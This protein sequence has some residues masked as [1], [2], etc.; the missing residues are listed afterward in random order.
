LPKLPPWFAC[1]DGI[2][3]DGSVVIKVTDTCP[4]NYPNNWYS[5]KRWC[6]GDMPHFD[7][8]VWAFERVSAGRDM[9]SQ[10]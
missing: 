9:A 1:R 3:K 8:S 7:L 2:C 6:C 10:G 4:C 5:N